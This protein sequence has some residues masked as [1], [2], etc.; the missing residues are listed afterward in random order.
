MMTRILAAALVAASCLPAR[1]QDPTPDAGF[2][3]IFNGKDL[4]G[5]VYGRKANG[6]HKMGAG[7]AVEHGVLSSTVKDGGYLY[8]EKEYADFT[9]RFEFRLTANAKSGI[10][11]RAPLE[12]DPAYVGLEIQVL[13]DSGS[14]FRNL[15]PD[16]YHGSVYDVFAA[17]RG[18]Q[19][20]VGEW[21]TE[22]ITA[23]GRHVTVTVNGQ[24]IVD[25]TLDDCKDEAKLKKHP[26]LQNPKGHLGILGQ[27]S[28]VEFRNLR[29]KEL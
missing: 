21:N 10:G 1:A 28:R 3:P 17:K 12:G 25:V 5:W 14:E 23:K 9:F 29:V 11:L 16:Q 13:D 4:T 6:E 27:G 2:T 19:K 8:T 15:H 24:V 20:D 7:Y 22:E 26:G 18:S